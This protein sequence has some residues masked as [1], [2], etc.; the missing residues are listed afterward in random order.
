MRFVAF[1]EDQGERYDHFVA[2]Q[3]AGSFLQ[4]SGWAA[5]QRQW[6]GR[7]SCRCGVVS[8]DGRVLLSAQLIEHRLPAGQRYWYAP[9]GPV[10]SDASAD[11][12]R[13]LGILVGELTA[14]LSGSMFLRFEPRFWGFDWAAVGTK[15]VNIQPGSTLLL[16]LAKPE[17]ELLAEMH[18]KT[19]YN[20]RL[21]ERRNVR[22]EQT[23]ALSPGHGLYFEEALD[24]IVRTASR[25][26]YL[27]YPK[28][29]YRQLLDFFALHEPGR[30][31]AS[32]Y[33]AVYQ[34]ELL[35][36]AVFVDFGN[37]RTYLFGGSSDQHR[38]VMAPYLLHWRA[39]Q[40]AKAL[41]LSTYDLGG[42]E[43][44]EGL[45]AGFAR[46]K[47][48]FGG[49]AAEFPGAYDVVLRPL[50]YHP[51]RYLRSLHRLARRRS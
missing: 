18:Q 45:R 1:G 8:Q 22:V 48:G 49:K 50:L 16:G 21:A 27:G 41:G 42:L 36:S 6:A 11:L 26:R 24:L 34:G 37:V 40:D 39:M 38:D 32:V 15:S 47:L 12:S 51:Y 2:S 33:K 19:R 30:V 14:R 44:G 3:A 31:R 9:Y 25:Q 29:Y 28:V 5:W 7:A 13:A 35:A 46:F 43:T 20:I 23:F 4:S 17:D 10:P